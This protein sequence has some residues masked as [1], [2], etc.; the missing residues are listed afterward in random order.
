MQTSVTDKGIFLISSD[1]TY[2]EAAK[3]GFRGDLVKEYDWNGL[4]VTDYRLPF[5][6]SAFCVAE[7]A[8]YAVSEDIGGTVIARV[9]LSSK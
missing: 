6:V 8:L 5:P 3:N 4:F 7:N 9:P 2:N 1:E